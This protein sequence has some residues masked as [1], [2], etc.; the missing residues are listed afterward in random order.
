V[1]LFTIRKPKQCFRLSVTLSWNPTTPQSFPQTRSCTPLRFESRICKH[2]SQNWISDLQKF[3]LT[4][5]S[6]LSKRLSKLG[7]WM[8]QSWIREAPVS[9]PKLISKIWIWMIQSWI[10]EAPVSNPNWISK[11][12]IIKYW[13]K[14]LQTKW[15]WNSCS[16][17]QSPGTA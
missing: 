14:K 7:F 4:G 8:I 16:K 11:I 3:Y 13:T 2:F 17:S 12:W 9:N 1:I 6:E 10:R 15:Q 5:S